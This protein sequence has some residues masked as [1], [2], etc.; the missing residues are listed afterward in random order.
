MRVAL[1]H[2]LFSIMN[3]SSIPKAFSSLGCHEL[4]LME[5][6]D[7]AERHGIGAVEVRSLEGTTDLPA[8]L[9]RAYGSP[10][11]LAGQLRGR[12]VRILALD[13]S[14]GLVTPSTADREAF[15]ACV[16]WAEALGVAWLRAFDG[17]KNPSDN[18]PADAAATMRWW[19]EQ[20]QQHG[21]RTDVMVET[22][23]TLLTAETVLRFCDLVP[24]AAILWDSHNTWRKANTDPVTMWRAIGSHVVHV[25]VKDSVSR[26]SGQFPYTYV[27]P[28][29]GEFPMARLLDALR[30]DH[31]AGAVS[32][33]WERQWHPSL[34]PLED[35]LRSAAGKN[36]W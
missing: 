25:H 2:A 30:A 36:W 7:L 24:G 22:H 31:Y 21:W 19:R 12:R 5:T 10:A 33:E 26:P 8:V 15:L 17:G 9:A 29:E 28:G 18:G 14:L 11:V 6:L 4:T 35:A 13:T 20:R 23:D 34:P 16:A 3:S 32:L 27:L 1:S